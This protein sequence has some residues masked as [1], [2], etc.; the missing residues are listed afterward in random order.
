MSQTVER[1]SASNISKSKNKRL[2]VSVRAAAF[3]L[4]FEKLFSFLSFSLLQ[5]KAK[6][7]F[8]SLKQLEPDNCSIVSASAWPQR[9]EV[10]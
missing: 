3:R 2:M 5:F 10:N 8:F 1:K 9:G 7:F 6:L 4:P